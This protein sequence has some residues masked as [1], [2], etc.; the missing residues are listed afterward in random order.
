MNSLQQILTYKA[1]RSRAIPWTLLGY[2]AIGLAA[3]GPRLLNLSGFVFVDEADFWM[4][5]SA[6]FLKA[7]QQGNP[8]ATAI[9]THPGVTTMWLGSAGII[10]QRW[11]AGL[12]LLSDSLPIRLALMRLPVAL[13][14]AAAVVA[15]YALLRRMLPAA[16]A[17][18][19]AL[20]WAADPFVIGYSQL[21]HV[22]GLAGT[23][24]TLSVLAACCYWFHQRRLTWLIFSGA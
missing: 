17:F 19:A 13:V 9:S 6:A 12:N 16:T 4:Q 20:L 15:G 21:L 22:D 23:F 14:N 7:L 1:V 10:L 2:L 24:M 3:L 8:A 5:R 11:L 18:L